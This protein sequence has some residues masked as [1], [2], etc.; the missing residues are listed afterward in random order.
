M[1]DR[2]S[3]KTAAAH[4][5]VDLDPTTVALRRW[6][7]TQK[8]ERLAWR[9][10]WADSGYVFTNEDG[11]PVGTEAV[12]HR[13]RRMTKAAGVPKIRLHDLRHTHASL[14]L[15]AG[16]PVHVVSRRLGHASAALTLS[17]H[18]HVLAAQQAEAAAAFSAFVD[19]AQ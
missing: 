2:E 16:V 10:A 15:K 18:S 8:A 13:F 1:H 19:G 4:R 11:Q 5:V 3:A 14:M 12:D 17:V 7:A 9:P 6:S